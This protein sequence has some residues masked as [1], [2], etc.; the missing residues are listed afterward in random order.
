MMVV[1]IIKQLIIDIDRDISIYKDNHRCKKTS[2][3]YKVGDIYC[4]DRT[5][6]M[7]VLEAHNPSNGK[8][9]GLAVPLNPLDVEKEQSKCSDYHYFEEILDLLGIEYY[10]YDEISYLR[11]HDFEQ[12]EKIRE[13]VMLQNIQ[14][15]N[16][17]DSCWIGIIPDLE[18][19]KTFSLL[20]DRYVYLRDKYYHDIV[21]LYDDKSIVKYSFRRVMSKT[22]NED[23]SKVLCYDLKKN[24]IV[25]LI[26]YSCRHYDE[27][28]GA[29]YYKANQAYK[30]LYTNILP[31]HYFEFWLNFKPMNLL[32][33]CLQQSEV[34]VLVRAAHMHDTRALKLC[35][36][37]KL[38]QIV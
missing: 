2:P 12:Y 18:Q 3:P 30:Y 35:M 19:I 15:Q 11:R 31:I 27:K 6:V 7:M 36:S 38:L 16:R 22:L 37:N 17:I 20:Q 9:Y 5:T 26:L 29:Y 10:D 8:R 25:G 34:A 13:K 14:H 4:P 33:G 1:E 24:E 28:N 23:G 21:K 32:R